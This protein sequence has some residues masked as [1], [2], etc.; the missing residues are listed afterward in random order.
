VKSLHLQ[1]SKI[2]N[3][4]IVVLTLASIII[5]FA[6]FLYPLSENQIWTLY[7]FDLFVTAMLAVDFYSRIKS[8]DNRLKY[9]IAHWY[10]FPAMIPLI[11]YGFADTSPV[12]QETIRTTRF[13]ALFR[14][15]RLYN[16]ALMV[17]GSEIL[18]LSSLAV[19]TVI[20]GGFGIYLT[21]S[22]SS[23]P[24]VNITNLNDA[25]WWAVETMTTVAY[26]EFYPVTPVGRIISTILMFSAIG[27]VWTAGALIISKLVEKRIKPT[28]TGLVEETK[29]MIKGKIDDI[30]K[31][32]KN[33]LESLIRMIRSL[34]N[35]V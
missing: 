32:N 5:I 17:K 21:E 15:V 9:V 3:V 26:G 6:E 22:Q 19:V 14:L 30:E 8:S 16:L 7:I 1:K 18:L 29:S 25:I 23:D 4:A 27:I 10:E 20:F 2:V 28:V 31:L 34:N 24:K 13:I 35:G 33:E 11:V 12:I